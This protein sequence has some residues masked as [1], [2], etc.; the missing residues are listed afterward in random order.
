MGMFDYVRCEVPIPGLD[1]TIA[2][3]FQTKDMNCLLDTYV[4]NSAGQ[5]LMNHSIFG[6]NHNPVSVC[7][8]F[9]GEMIFCGF[10]K[11]KLEDFSATF[12][13]GLLTELK[14]LHYDDDVDD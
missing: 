5:L 2:R 11:N 6:T 14:W 1:D 13:D 10:V 3:E 7:I 4:I 12:K 8:E 9:T